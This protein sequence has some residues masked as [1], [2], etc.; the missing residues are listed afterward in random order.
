V[1]IDLDF[2]TVTGAQRFLEFRRTSVWSFPGRAPALAGPPTTRIFASVEATADVFAQRRA[3]GA[4]MMGGGGV[5][6]DRDV[7][8]GGA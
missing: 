5:T 4:G 8:G 1:T 7:A 2:A 3:T 6:D